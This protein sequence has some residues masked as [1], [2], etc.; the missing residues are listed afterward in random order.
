MAQRQRARR[1]RSQIAQVYPHPRGPEFNVLHGIIP[2]KSGFTPTTTEPD[3]SQQQRATD[4]D[5]QWF[6]RQKFLS[7]FAFLVYTNRNANDY[8]H[9]FYGRGMELPASFST[10][11][12]WPGNI[13]PETGTA[14][15]V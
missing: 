4:E 7:Q 5:L 10:P 9:R 2:L 3:A 13:I 8:L 1:P 6:Q 14:P 11:R 15:S 12:N